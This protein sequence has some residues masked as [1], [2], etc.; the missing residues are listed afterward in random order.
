MTTFAYPNSPYPIREDIRAAHR[1]TW[2]AIATPGCWWSGA[3]RVAIAAEVRNAHSCRLCAE[4][5]ASLAPYSVSG[6][7]DHGGDL[8]AAAI[9]A[10][11][12]LTTDSRRLKISWYEEL[13]ESGLTD[14]H[15]VEIVGIVM[16]MVSVDG[17]NQALG[18]ALEPL[19]EPRP[20]Q[21]TEYRPAGAQPGQAWV[22][23]IPADAATGAEA[24]LYFGGKQVANVIAAMSLVPDAVRLLRVLSAAHYVHHAPD[25]AGLDAGERAISPAQMEFIA[26]R[27]SAMNECFY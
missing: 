20:G 23:M 3:E 10:V 14:G 12:R 11:H 24:D 19:P 6:E 7:H 4:R 15:Y 13:M 9:E 17:F 21:S 2:D 8:P 27:V 1:Q 16:A 22:P 18:V 25:S 26:A 5:Q